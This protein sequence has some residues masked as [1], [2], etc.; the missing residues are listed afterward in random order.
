MI[1]MRLINIIVCFMLVVQ[2]VLAQTISAEK[3]QKDVLQLG[4]ASSGTNKSLTFD[5]GEGASNK[6]LE[7]DAITKQLSANT[8]LT[9]SSL[10]ATGAVS[11]S[12]LNVEST[13]TLKGN[14]TARDGT[15]GDWSLTVNKGSANPY[16]KWNNTLTKWTFSNDGSVEKKLGSGSGSGDGGINLLDNSSFEDG[17]NVAWVSSGGTYSQQAY[18]STSANVDDLYFGRLVATASGQFLETS[19]VAV[20][21]FLVGQCVAYSKYNTSNASSWKIQVLTSANVLVKEES[22]GTS[23]WESSKYVAFPCPTAGTSIKLRYVST[24][25]G[26]VEI[27]KA[28][29]GSENRIVTVYDDTPVGTVISSLL[30][31]AQFQSE[32]GTNWVLADGRTIASTTKFAQLYGSTTIPDLRGQFLRGKNNGRADGNQDPAGER[33]LGVYQADQ[34]QGHW[35]NFFGEDGGIGSAGRYRVSTNST[36]G[37]SNVVTNPI[38]DGTNGTPRTGNE[39]RVKNVAVNYFIKIDGMAVKVI[40]DVGYALRAG[41][42]ISGAFSACPANTLEANGDAVSKLDYPQ[43]FSA[44]GTSHGDGTKLADGVT[45][46]SFTSGNGFNLPDYRGRFLRGHANGSANDPDRATRT[47]MNVGGSAGDNVGSVQGDAIR[48]ITGSVDNARYDD[49]P[50]ASGAYTLTAGA[51]GSGF[52]SGSNGNFLLNFNASN[53]VPTGADNRPK[54]ASVKF[55]I[56]TVNTQISGT[57]AQIDDLKTE[58]DARPYVTESYRSGNA[59][60]K[61]WSNG[62]LE[63]GNYVASAGNGVTATLVTPFIDTN[64]NPQVTP[65][66][67]GSAGSYGHS[68]HTKTVSNFKAN[69]PTDNGGFHWIAIGRWK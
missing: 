52:I 53:V 50:S 6:K 69:I 13:S 56:Q 57:F 38:T 39:T 14:L 47:A 12:T 62:D 63:Q 4:R 48:N 33:S 10:T 36:T 17:P 19:A 11:A 8:G 40:Q 26:T 37:L 68:A 34:F 22:L 24:A 15:S 18:S 43:L 23:A 7:L 45:N 55:C 30:T 42:I 49:G 25:V 20:P 65:Y 61:K 32:R 21:T 66:G 64:Y 51:G 31:E 3:I 27:D 44:I 54:N 67:S 28:Y 41:Q 60:Y 16:L 46:S 35:H 2:P 1:M 5:T 58:I 59:Y 9:A 29:L